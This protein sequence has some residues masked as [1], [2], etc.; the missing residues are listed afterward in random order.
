MKRLFICAERF[1]PRGDAG[2]NRILYIA[3]ALQRRDWK[4]L[5]LSIGTNNPLE[6]HESKNGY[7]Y[8]GIQYENIVCYTSGFFQKIE[9]M[10][11]NGDKTVKLLQ[12]YQL[13]RNDK[14]LIYSSTDRYTRTIL[15]Y[16]KF[17][18]GA[19]CVVDVVEWHQ[20]YQFKYGKIDPR[21][22]SFE[23]C[24][25]QLFVDTRNVVVISELLKRHFE[26]KGCNVLK[27]PIYIEPK[28]TYEYIPE[29]S[30]VNL[31]YPGNP[32]RKDSLETM[33]EALNMLSVEE[34]KRVCLHLT[35]VSRKALEKSVVG[36]ECLLNLACVKIHGW[37]EYNELVTLYQ[38]IDFALIARPDNLVT[39]ANFP[40][41]VPELMSWGI[42]VIINRVGDIQEHLCEGKDCIFIEES[43]SKGCLNAIRKCMGKEREKIVQMHEYAFE[44]AQREF[45]YSICEE[46]LDDFF[47]K[48][49]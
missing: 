43:T 41:K 5:V 22:R 47:Y 23:K 31:I 32:Y 49:I 29:K 19:K 1:F 27:L 25:N 6:Y 30:C 3:K 36:K 10:F 48:R 42:P 14:V 8:D 17:A 4:V 7:Y 44:T 37:M 28:E 39:N 16:A 40:S 35:G 12:K 13:T 2:A 46:M 33:L 21:Y 11:F 38:K 15:E 18:V 34:Q 45:D 26:D 24:F 20:P 9:R